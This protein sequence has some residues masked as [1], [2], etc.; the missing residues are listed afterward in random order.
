MRTANRAARI[1]LLL[2]AAAA[3]VGAG[4]T[5]QTG[6]MAERM[7]EDRLIALAQQLR[8]GMTL[9]TVAAYSPTPGDLRIHAQQ[10]VNLLEGTEG[11]H[12]TRPI[13]PTEEIPGLL[14]EITTLGARFEVVPIEVETR[15]RIVAAARN[16]RAFMTFA[17]EEALS[18]IEERRIDRAASAMLRA[19]AFLL[20]AYEQP[21]D[22]PYVPALWT[23]LRA[24]ELTERL[25]ARS[26]TAG[27]QE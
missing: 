11:K 14:V 12:F 13:P 19:Y 26:E 17:L 18:A 2:V 8:M 23:I 10:L 3:I 27:E 21:C 20:A 25:G 5:G 15:D 1:A 9:A 7:I 6:Q 16:V 22:A 24:F 4:Q